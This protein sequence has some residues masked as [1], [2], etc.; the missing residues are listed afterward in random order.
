MANNEHVIMFWSPRVERVIPEDLWK[1]DRVID[2]PDEINSA[3][4]DEAARNL[5][6]VLREEITKAK[7]KRVPLRVVQLG[8]SAFSG[9]VE[10][11]INT[12]LVPVGGEL[13]VTKTKKR[14]ENSPTVIVDD[15]TADYIVSKMNG[16]IDFNSPPV[17]DARLYKDELPASLEP[18]SEFIKTRQR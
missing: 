13:I 7:Q 11:V 2:V 18:P 10:H 8:P 12:I 5:T 15:A 4:V 3:E 16:F 1:A 6:T 9:I 17:T 14:D